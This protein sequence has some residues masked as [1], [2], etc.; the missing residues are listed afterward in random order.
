MEN[1]QV[2]EKFVSI[3]GE[4]KRAGELA[5]F[6]RFKGCNLSCNYCDTSW[7][8]EPDCAAKQMTKEEI[9]ADIQKTGVRNIT[10]TG[11]E[12]L[13]QE[14]IEQLISLIL[15]EPFYRVEI[16]TNG[17]V[18][19]S[20]YTKMER[21]PSITMDYKLAESGMEKKMLLE[22]LSKLSVQDSLKFVVSSRRDMERAYE[23]IQQY[24]LLEKVS[25]FF[26]PVFGRI[27][28]VELVNFLMEHKLNDVKVQLQL[29]KVIWDP[30]QRGV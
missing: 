4:G 16:E 9:L 3:N 6:I 24:E 26:S 30:E 7:A 2:V 8:N 28:P 23:I 22:N 1:F 27:E 5:L 19:I 17:S 10:L 21:R 25:I 18:D 15:K 13:L 14:G 11:G 12:P 20:R 29:H